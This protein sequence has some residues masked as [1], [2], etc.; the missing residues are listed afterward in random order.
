MI[1]GEG[2]IYCMYAEYSHRP[3]RCM[4]LSD[5]AFSDSIFLTG[6]DISEILL[7]LMWRVQQGSPVI[8][9]CV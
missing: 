2:N 5:V 9:I 7:Y 1:S 6:L 8:N 4:F 3:L